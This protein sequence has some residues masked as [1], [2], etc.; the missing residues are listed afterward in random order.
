MKKLLMCL[1]NALLE[2]FNTDV[3][4]VGPREGLPYKRTPPTEPPV[5]STPIYPE[6]KKE[7]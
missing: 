4:I 6:L 3:V 5:N 7:E 1:W 2:L